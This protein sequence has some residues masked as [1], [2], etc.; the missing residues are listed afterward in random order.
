MHAWRSQ[1]RRGASGKYVYNTSNPKTGRSVYHL[2]KS[3]HTLC[4]VFLHGLQVISLTDPLPPGI[5]LALGQ[6]LALMQT[7]GG[8]GIRGRE[9]DRLLVQRDLLRHGLAQLFLLLVVFCTL[10]LGHFWEGVC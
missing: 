6:V 7:L 4:V 2:E 3:A 9:I 1:R 10:L 5:A 8:A